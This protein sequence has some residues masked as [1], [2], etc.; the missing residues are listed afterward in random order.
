MK[1]G[2]D[3]IGVGVVFL[4]HDGAGNILLGKRGASA[5]DEQ[6]RWDPGGGGVHVGETF[7]QAVVREVA[8]EYGATILDITPLGYRQV[9]REL[10]N[11]TNTHWIVF[12]FA[13]HVDQQ[14]AVNREPEKCDQ[15]GWFTLST[16]PTLMHSQWPVFYKKYKISLGSICALS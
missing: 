11:G 3:Y 5:R 15:I 12:D 2:E 16:L 8:E 13:V 14:T 9:H 10:D 6:G 4:C 7:E 1:K